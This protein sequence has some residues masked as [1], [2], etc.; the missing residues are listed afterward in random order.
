MNGWRR[1]VWGLALSVS[2][3]RQGDV[4]ARPL[5]RLA[6]RP[7][8]PAVHLDDAPGDGQ[9]QPQP[10]GRRVQ[11]IRRGGRSSPGARPGC[12]DRRRAPASST[13]RPCRRPETVTPVPHRVG[14]WAVRQQVDDGLTRL[15]ALARGGQRLG[16]VN[17]QC[18]PLRRRQHPGLPPESLSPSGLARRRQRGSILLRLVSS[19]HGSVDDRIVPPQSGGVAQFDEAIKG[20]CYAH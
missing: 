4:N 6:L 10:P 2:V 19:R 12:Q 17:R 1:T 11:P 13:S 16:P 14:A 18:L 15:E 8:P 3:G 20:S 5:A 7:D 9:P